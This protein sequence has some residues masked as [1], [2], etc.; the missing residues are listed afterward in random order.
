[1][2]LE[3]FR[4]VDKKQLLD[5]FLTNEQVVIQVYEQLFPHRAPKL[6][7]NEVSYVQMQ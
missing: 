1:M 3:E 7:E 6:D 2:T 5:M 4:G